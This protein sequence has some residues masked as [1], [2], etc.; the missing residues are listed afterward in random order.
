MYK[1]N[2]TKSIAEAAKKVMDEELKGQQHKIDA[3]KNNKTKI[4]ESNVNF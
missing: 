4:G 3:N 2:L 1:D